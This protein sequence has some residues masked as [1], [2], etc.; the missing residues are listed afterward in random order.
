MPRRRG[1]DRAGDVE[2]RAAGPRRRRAGPAR[3]ARSRRG[4]T[5]SAAIAPTSSSVNVAGLAG[6]RGAEPARGEVAVHDQAHRLADGVAAHVVGGRRERVE[7]VARRLAA[8]RPTRRRRARAGRMRRRSASRRMPR[9]LT[10]LLGRAPPARVVLGAAR[11]RRVTRV[12]SRVGARPA[13]RPGLGVGERRDRGVAAPGRSRSSASRTN[14]G[15]AVS[16]SRS[17]KPSSA[18]R[19]ARSSRCGHGRSGF[20]WSAVSGETPP[21]SSAPARTQQVELGRVRE[22]RRHLD[23][24]CAAPSRAGRRRRPRR[25][26]AATASGAPCIAVRG[27]ARKFWTMTSCT[28]PCP[29]TAC[30]RGRRGSRRATR[31]GRA[32]SRRCRPGC[33]W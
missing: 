4:P 5:A 25:T 30:A 27:F 18:V 14:S 9:E 24:A 23:R 19:A 32:G 17:S 1:L 13:A 31:P 26:R 8:A 15:C 22:V 3:R 11:S 29:S 21:Q 20:T 33:R 16:R 2:V 7:V 10:P 6:R 28:W 12:I